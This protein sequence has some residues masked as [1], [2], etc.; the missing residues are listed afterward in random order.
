MP[1]KYEKW[2]KNELIEYIRQR[3]NSKKYGLVWEE[4]VENSVPDIQIPTLVEDKS[5]RIHKKY[6]STN[7]ELSQI[8]LDLNPE[9]EYHNDHNFHILIESDNE[10]A[11]RA[12][13]ALYAQKIDIIYIDPPYNTGSKD[14][15]YKDSYRR[16]THEYRHSEWLSFMEKRL[17]LAY[18]LL[19]DDGIIFISIDDNE[20]AHLRLLL[21]EIFGEHNFIVNIV[22]RC[23]SGAGHDTDK[24]AIEFDYV[25]CYGKN[26][27]QTVFAQQEVHTEKDKKYKYSDEYSGRRGK[28][29]LRDLDYK[30]SYSKTL[31]Y[32]ITMPDGTILY[33]G[34]AEGKPN[35]WRWSKQKYD[36]GKE[37]GFIV[38]KKNKSGQWKV[39]IKQY[40]YVDNNDIIRRRYI[41]YR[42]LC[43]FM[44]GSGSNELRSILHQDIFHYPKPTGLIKFLIGLHT[45]SRHV[46]VLDF[47]AGSG[48]TG[49]AVLALNKQ[50]GGNRQCI[51]ITNNENN[52]CTD[53]CYPRLKNIMSGY[54]DSKNKEIQGI[55]GELRYYTIEEKTTK[56]RKKN[57]DD[58]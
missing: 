15:R 32:P 13:T 26:A 10:P 8:S 1:N 24:V 34:G 39:Y 51:L 19:A 27:A 14:F 12:L 17:R 54:K 3:E 2:T 5:R 6:S 20:H 57:H 52:I 55:G 49:H 7:N 25:L 38:E 23:K 33:A 42:G 4:S 18:T 22:R 50:D 16:H 53:V 37:H 11:L 41:P 43:E 44:N 48:T 40:Q 58:A 21:D 36:W 28:Y 35:T 30:G 56:H 9:E 31:D 46:R 45:N 29:Y 47:F